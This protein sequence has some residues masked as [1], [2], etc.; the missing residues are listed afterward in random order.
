[1]PPVVI[2]V[3]AAADIRDVVHQAVQAVSEGKLVVFPTE[4]V[5]GLA[6]RA[7]DEDAVARLIE[8]KG[9]QPRHPFTLAIR[10]VDAARDYAPD[11]SPLAHRLARR[12]WPGPVTLVIDRSHPESLVQ[13]LPPSVQSVVSPGNTVG[14]RVAG[15]QI[16]L[17]VLRMVAGPLVLTSANRGGQPEAQTAAEAIEALGD[18]VQFVLDD[19]PCRFGQPSSVVQ[20]TD[21][22]YEILREGVVPQE[23]LARL[24]ALML[25]FVCTG[26]TCRSP[27]AESLCRQMLAKRFGC[28]GDEL[29][30]KAVI[31][32]SAG[33]AAMTGGRASEEAVRVMADS[34]IDLSG[35]ETQPLTESLVRYADVMYTMTQSHRHAILAQWPGA[36]PRTH[37]LAADGSDIADPIGGPEERYRRC[38]AQIRAELETRLDELA[39][40]AK[41]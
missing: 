28:L 2:D 19:G 5:Y 26:N 25:L 9:R 18:E 35:H 38:A 4:T 32:A 7:L 3:N 22:R 37:L 14:L 40:E 8:V 12:C 15:H 30:E 31:I 16:V 11:M 23:T 17:E 39:L 6:A 20:V 33:V 13:R 21:D 27:M 41:N 34:K 24:S 29:E 10:N 1:M 36:A